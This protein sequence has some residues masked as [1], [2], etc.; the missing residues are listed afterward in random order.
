[1]DTRQDLTGLFTEKPQSGDVTVGESQ[2]GLSGIMWGHR[3]WVALSTG[4][5]VKADEVEC[6]TN[7]DCGS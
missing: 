5:T 4:A 2:P 6:I 3:S 7:L 1:M